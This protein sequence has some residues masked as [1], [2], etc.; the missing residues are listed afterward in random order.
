METAKGMSRVHVKVE[1][2]STF[3]FLLSFRHTMPLQLNLSTMA[4]SGT[5]ESGR[6][7]GVARVIGRF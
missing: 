4:T 7:K 2:P 3:T 5:E 6:C 1:P